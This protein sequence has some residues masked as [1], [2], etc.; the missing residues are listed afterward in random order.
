MSRAL[1]LSR[2]LVKLMVL[3]ELIDG[4]SRRMTAKTNGRKLTA[5]PARV[6]MSLNVFAF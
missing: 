1:L 2:N 3:S 5:D 6:P 4:A